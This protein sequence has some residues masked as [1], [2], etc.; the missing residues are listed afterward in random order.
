[1]DDECSFCGRA[2]QAVHVLFCQDCHAQHK[3]CAHC[4]DE[5]ANE[6]DLY[7]PVA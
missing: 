3:V 6:A 4:A 7:R 2:G 1:M 5:V